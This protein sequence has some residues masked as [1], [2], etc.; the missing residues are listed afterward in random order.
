MDDTLAAAAA[1][2]VPARE[3]TS[4]ITRPRLLPRSILGTAVLVLALGIGAAVS[5]AVLYAYYQY[6]LAATEQ[7]VSDYV[8]GFNQRFSA[9]ESSLAAEANKATAEVT[10]AMAPLRQAN[11]SSAELTPLAKQLSGAV[12]FLHSLDQSGQLAVGSAFAVATNASETFLLT[13]YTPIASATQQGGPPIYV[14][15]NNGHT[16]TATLVTWKAAD[17][18]ALLSI[19]LGNQPTLKFA[20]ANPVPQ[21][22]DQILAVSGLT[23]GSGVAISAGRVA[24]VAT[25]AIQEDAPTG[26]AFVGGPLVNSDGQVVGVSAPAYQPD[27]FQSSSVYFAPTTSV[28]CSSVLR[29]PN[30]TPTA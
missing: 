17:Q 11:A 21:P 26:T 5:G 20:P 19:P 12:Y 2:D 13:A 4:P 28:A 9:S 8:S 14:V 22:G 16:M 23:S 24:Q 6:R 25:N 3:S 1:D 15:G 27:G 18:L 30:G 29:C 7:V 10:Q